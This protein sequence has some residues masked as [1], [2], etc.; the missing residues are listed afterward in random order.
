MFVQCL[1]TYVNTVWTLQLSFQWHV[2]VR[3]I[4]LGRFGLVV[5][6]ADC[7]KADGVSTQSEVCVLLHT[8]V[9]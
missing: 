7:A 6:V 4:Y 9:T 8:S 3:S 1:L 2:P 5:S